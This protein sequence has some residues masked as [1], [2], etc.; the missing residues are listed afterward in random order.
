MTCGSRSAAHFPE[1][2]IACPR[3]PPRTAPNILQGWGS[4]Q[5]VVFSHGWPLSADAWDDQMLFPAARA[6]A[7]SPHDRRATAG[8]A[9]VDG[10]EMDTYADDLAALSSDSAEPKR[11]P[12]RPLHGRRR[13]RPHIGRHAR[14]GGQGGPDQRGPPLMPQDRGESR[15]TPIEASTRSA[16][17]PRRALAVLQGPERAV[18]WHQPARRGQHGR[19]CGTR[20]VQGMLADSRACSMYQGL[21]GDRFPEDLK[22]STCP[23]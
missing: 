10:N 1:E 8:Q 19:A 13:S 20:S 7:A 18:L 14:T 11:D 2:M 21:L 6:T 22:R 5:P 3:S 4:G 9:T 15:R 17:V 16:P 23:T 12:R